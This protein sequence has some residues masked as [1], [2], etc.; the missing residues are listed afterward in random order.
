MST[1][2]PWCRITVL[3]ADGEALTEGLLRGSGCPDLGAIDVIARVALLARRRGGAVVLRD[4]T[5][6]LR[7]L[8]ELA[9]LRVE[10]Q[11]QPEGRE[12][13]LWIEEVEEEGH[14]GHA[15]A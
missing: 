13:A 9:G 6:E 1:A 11:R 7:A 5:A 8:L 2:R 3:A 15:P 4:V 10:V 12:E 14:P